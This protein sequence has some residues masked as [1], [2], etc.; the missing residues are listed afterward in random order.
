MNEASGDV[1][2]DEAFALLGN[3]TR[4]A[5]LRALAN[6]GSP[7]S[8]S[9]LRE[10]VGMRDSGQFNYHLGKLT[11][12][13]I[14]KVE[15]GYRMRYAGS[16]VVGA[17]HAGAYEHAASVGPFT[18]A[19]PCPACGGALEFAYENERASVI[20]AACERTSLDGAVPPGVFDGYE[21][22]EYPLVFDRW[23]RSKARGAVEGFCLSCEGRTTPE[24]LLDADSWATDNR[25]VK[26]GCRR[27][28]EAVFMTV[29][30]AL[31]F[32]PAVIAFHHDHGVSPTAEPTWRLQWLEETTVETV[33]TDPLRIRAT[34]HVGDGTLTL[35]VD[36]SL[37]VVE[38]TTTP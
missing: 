35:T 10:R 32:D 26:F 4:V 17:I 5:I 23:L 16:H 28:E 24:V 37:S 36:D 30:E 33:S 3:E 9:T 13:F 34:G 20:C 1:R 11:G 27:C 25:M 19:D 22:D 18:L 8:F 7:I 21:R 15:D 14:D 2:P 31:M 38:T 12:V 29:P 6:A